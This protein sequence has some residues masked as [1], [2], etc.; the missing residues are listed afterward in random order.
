V[1]D[2]VASGTTM[3]DDQNLVML[4]K[5]IEILLFLHAL[6]ALAW[7]AG[8]PSFL[9]FTIFFLSTVILIAIWTT[10]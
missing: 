10:S 3:N 9:P 7:I 6:S 8:A 1:G 5:I 2:T 4:V